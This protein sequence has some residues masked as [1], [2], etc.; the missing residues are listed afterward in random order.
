[1]LRAI[2]DSIGHQFKAHRPLHD[3]VGPDSPTTCNTPEPPA[4]QESWLQPP[5]FWEHTHISY[6]MKSASCDL[7][8]M[9]RRAL[10]RLNPF[11]WS[12][13]EGRVS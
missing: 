5:S 11:G 3:T 4:C 2:M 6:I 9:G 10:I 13:A 12:F 7:F 1:M 8:A